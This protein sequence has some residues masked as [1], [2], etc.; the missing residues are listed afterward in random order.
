MV[1]GLIIERKSPVIAIIFL[2]DRG[3]KVTMPNRPE[4][5]VYVC[6]CVCL[7]VLHVTCVC[8]HYSDD[9]NTGARPSSSSLTVS[10]V[11]VVTKYKMKVRKRVYEMNGLSN[12]SLFL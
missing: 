5:G 1:T 3:Q 4:R 7:C 10:Y 12:F 8:I 9:G 11:T 6:V 2:N